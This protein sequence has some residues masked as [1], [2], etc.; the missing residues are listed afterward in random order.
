MDTLRTPSPLS[1]SR[2]KLNNKVNETL[3]PDIKP[4]KCKDYD[5]PCSKYPQCGELLIRT[6][7][8]G[9]SGSGKMYFIAKS[10]TLYL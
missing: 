7:L 1:L 6:V 5:I 4:I 9:P 2:K 10:H 3:K 8:L